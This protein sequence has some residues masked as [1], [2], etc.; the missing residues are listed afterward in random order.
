[1]SLRE[2]VLHDKLWKLVYKMSLPGILSMFLV[3]FNSFIDALFA[4]RIIGGN[5]LAGISLSIPLLVLNSAAIG[6][7][8]S[9][10][11]NVLSR[12]IGNQN[13]TVLQQVLNYVLV[14]VALV[15][16][17]LGFLGF[18]F[19]SPL[20]QLM[21]AEGGILAEGISYYKWMMV[22]SFTSFLGLSLSALIR[23]EGQMKYTMRIT[24]V[25]VIINIMLNA[26]FMLYLGMG[27]KG[28][29]LATVA[30]MGVYA[31]LCLSHFKAGKSVAK[32]NISG[33][34]YHHSI[35]LEITSIGV[36]AL[37]MQLSGFLRQVLLFK[38]VT[39]Y[40][41]N[42]EVAFFSAVF[43]IFSFSVIPIFGMLQAM[44]PIVGINFGAENYNRSLAAL[45]IFRF[46]SSGLMFLILTPVFL[47]PT[48]VLSLLLPDY[49][50]STEQIFHFRLMMS[51]LLI[52]PFSSTAMVFLLATG[53][54]RICTYL[55]FGR[56]VVLFIPIM[57]LMP[58]LF[59]KS[60][61]YYGLFLENT[62]YMVVI[63]LVLMGQTKKQF[64]E[65]SLSI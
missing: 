46:T 33:F 64:H 20:L 41:S 59:G 42:T 63:V 31:I 54:G 17:L 36:S 15:S 12:A 43:R 19:A 35:I 4:G 52:A 21:G 56:E 60:G 30:A 57:L 10:A 32:F 37:M 2:S 22:G 16:L 58:Y 9:G 7:I 39:W 28:S 29:A 53:N 6:F 34:Q 8:S 51:I 18:F 44:Q 62:I 11:A 3:S 26:L 25:A 47:F 48:E 38:T 49:S 24:A 40:S 1:M 5:A 50:F 23:A 13:K 65:K 55:S 14:Y 27:V 45:R 61:V